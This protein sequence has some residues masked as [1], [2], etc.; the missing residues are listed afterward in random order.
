MILKKVSNIHSF[1]RGDT[2]S[3][4]KE[5]AGPISTKLP[6]KHPCVKGIQVYSNEEQYPFT[7]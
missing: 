5:L 4:P 2:K 7:C 6:T 1:R 3:A